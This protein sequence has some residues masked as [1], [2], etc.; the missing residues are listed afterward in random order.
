MQLANCQLGAAHDLQV[1]II[2]TD[3]N[4]RAA[5]PLAERRHCPTIGTPLD[6]RAPW[7]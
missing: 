6:R 5:G 2:A 4:E 3:R 1:G 7:V